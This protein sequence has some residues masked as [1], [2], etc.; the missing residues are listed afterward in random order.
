MLTCTRHSR[1]NGPRSLQTYAQSLAAAIPGRIGFDCFEELALAAEIDASALE[2]AWAIYG[3][4]WRSNCGTRSATPIRPSAIRPSLP[5]HCPRASAA[6]PGMMSRS[7]GRWRGFNFFQ[8]P[9]LQRR[10]YIY[11]HNW[12]C[13][14]RGWSSWPGID[15]LAAFIDS[16]LLGG[17]IL[18]LM[19][20][21]ADLGTKPSSTCGQRDRA[22]AGDSIRISVSSGI[23]HGRAPKYA[24]AVSRKILAGQAQPL[25]HIVV[26][27]DFRA[28]RARVG[29]RLGRTADNSGRVA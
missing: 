11:T 7:C 14:L 27:T 16:Q 17:Q 15:D 5:S 1:H 21:Q 29:K 8:L 19:V 10:R 12:N 9:R 6:S 20:G 22:A 4:R 3:T 18:P 24:L 2:A 28:H 23:R 26:H 25:P 13:A